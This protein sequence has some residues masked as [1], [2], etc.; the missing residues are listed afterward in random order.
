M[1]EKPFILISNDDGIYSDG[2][3][4][5]AQVGAEFGDVI[6][7]A[8][9]RQQSAVGHAITLETPLRAQ[10]MMVHGSFDGFAIN[11]TPADCV[12]LAHDQLLNRKP[13]LVLSV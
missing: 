12:K 5:L 13:D 4:A 3:K 10:N 2:I 8:P 11:G 1:S 7:I 6:V 9:D